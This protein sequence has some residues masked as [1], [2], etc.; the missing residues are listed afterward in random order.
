MLLMIINFNILLQSCE[1][2]VKYNEF[3]VKGFES[4]TRLLSLQIKNDGKAIQ[5]HLVQK[6]KCQENHISCPVL[7]NLAFCLLI[8]Y[9]SSET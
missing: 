9:S 6:L 1:F 5:M 7:E 4:F 2:E 8:Y 3:E